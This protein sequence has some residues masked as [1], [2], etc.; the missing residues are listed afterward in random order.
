M[1]R[2]G[3]R[4]FEGYY[5]DDH[6]GSARVR[7]GAYWTG[8]LGYR[9]EQGFFYFAGRGNDRL[10][11]DSENLAAAPIERILERH[12]DVAAAAVYPVPDPRSG[13]AVMA[14]IELRP[15]RAFDGE[16]FAV[17]LAA[18]PDLGTKWAPRFVRVVA[19]MPVTATGKIT[20]PGLVADGWAGA[21]AV[22]WRPGPGT[23]YRPLDPEDREVLRREFDRHGRLGLLGG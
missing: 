9:D 20:K 21:P 6:A 16:G 10:R 3:A 2:S 12:P 22:H 8:D 4:G 13:D 11:V 14:A 19:A 18:Q 23:P 5:K 7:D 17:F 15:G 1:N